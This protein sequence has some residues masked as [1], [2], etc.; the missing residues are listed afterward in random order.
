MSLTSI[1]KTKEVRQKFSEILRYPEINRKIEIKAPPLTTNYSI[2]GSAF[3]YLLRFFIESINSV[4]V[5]MDWIAHNSI[6]LRA[7]I[8]SGED[9]EISRKIIEKA[10]D[11][12]W[13]FITNKKMTRELAESCIQLGKLDIFYRSGVN[14]DLK[15]VSIEDIQD[16]ENLYSLI[17]IKHWNKNNKYILNP[18]F[19]AGS[20]VVGGADAD[21]INDDM[22]VEIKT[23]QKMDLFKESINQLIGYHI[24]NEIDQRKSTGTRIK[25]IG[26][27]YS[28]FGVLLEFDLNTLLTPQ[29]E[30][31]LAKWLIDYCNINKRKQL[32][33]S[34]ST[35]LVTI[36]LGDE[37]KRIQLVD[38]S[39]ENCIV[40]YIEGREIEIFDEYFGEVLKQL[41]P[42]D[43]APFYKEL[44]KRIEALMGSHSDAI[45]KGCTLRG[46]ER[47]VNRL[48]K[49]NATLKR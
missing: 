27:Y 14:I 8:T 21:L 10:E 19:G 6:E 36:G 12:C 2:V 29:D 35:D 46:F 13:K 16:I 32:K 1:V 23:V 20:I 15:E 47:T 34:K 25:R 4:E 38:D 37:K 5:S 9:L 33:E 48:K 3:D 24:L 40:P 17:D 42:N 43:T 49:K 26:I 28:R 41:N 18:T 39:A 7:D 11:E 30:K 22:L 45:F 31:Y 44:G